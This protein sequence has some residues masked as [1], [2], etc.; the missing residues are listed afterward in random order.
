MD[1][2]FFVA[3]LLTAV[4]VALTPVLFPTPKRAIPRTAADSA[5]LDSARLAE[6]SAVASP[7]VLQR[8]DSLAT[9]RPLAPASTPVSAERPDS[10]GAVSVAS[11]ETTTVETTK[12][13]YRFSSLGAAPVSVELKDYKSYV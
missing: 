3:L 10:L 11:V 8:T 9:P 4:V 5:R 6:R 13:A 7:S 1:K 12:A 2:R